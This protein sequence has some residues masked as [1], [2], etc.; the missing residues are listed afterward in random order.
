[1]LFFSIIALYIINVLLEK[2]GLNL[3]Y[4]S[5]SQYLDDLGI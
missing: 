2:K 4:H 1:M 5:M 3:G